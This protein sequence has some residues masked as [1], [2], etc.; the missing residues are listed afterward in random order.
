MNKLIY[1]LYLMSAVA[2][3]TSGKLFTPMKAI[4]LFTP[5][6]A[7]IEVKFVALVT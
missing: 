1:E 6:K 7:I 3:G 4:I 2:S 5:M